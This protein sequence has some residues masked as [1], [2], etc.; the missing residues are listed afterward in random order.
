MAIVLLT[1]PAALGDADCAALVVPAKTQAAPVPATVRASL[2]DAGST[3]MRH[4]CR[5]RLE[6]NRVRPDEL[7]RLSRE[8]REQRLTVGR[9]RHDPDF[10]MIEQ[11]LDVQLRRP[12]KPLRDLV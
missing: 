1:S 4:M 2:Q 3:S 10:V 12:R 8:S 11:I 5:I 7:P 6:T 9:V